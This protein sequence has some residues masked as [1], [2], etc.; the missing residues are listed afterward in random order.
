M[1]PI[2]LV[3]SL[4]VTACGS[5]GAQGA[6]PGTAL[7]A[8]RIPPQ[9]ATS[10][11]PASEIQFAGLPPLVPI[12]PRVVCVLNGSASSSAY[13]AGYSQVFALNDDRRLQLY[14][15][16]GAK[17]VKD[18]P[19]QTL[20]S[21]T[22]DIGG[23]TWTWTVLANGVTTL[24][25]VTLGSYVE[26]AL[27][28]DETQVDTLVDIA[29][30]LRPVETLPRP[31]A[32]RICASLDVTSG[33]TKVAA[34]FDSSAKSVVTWHETP[35]TANGP[36]P[37]SEWRQ[38]PPTEPVAVCYL[39]GDFGPPRGPAPPLGASDHRPNYD[40]VVY[41]VGVDRRPTAIVFGWQDRIPVRDP[42]P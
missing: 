3:C 4:L 36:R 15:R 5:G 13:D 37:V 40:R 38:H 6:A 41:V 34:S 31:S 9:C 32:A 16:R 17:P 14:E 1:R 30:A 2:V 27:P 35:L 7:S 42:G 23:V 11:R 8:D 28:G 10:V 39:D 20:R 12:S 19:S 18:A 24:S 22:R 21:G 33:P 29:S 25:A 26:L